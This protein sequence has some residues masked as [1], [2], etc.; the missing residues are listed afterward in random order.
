MNDSSSIKTNRT[1]DIAGGKTGEDWYN[2]RNAL[3]DPQT[4]LPKGDLAQWESVF[5]T[6]FE[7]RL[8]TRY[9]EPIR[10]I[11][12]MDLWHGEGFSIVAIQCSLIEFLQ[13][14]VEG[15]NYKYKNPQEPY[16]YNESRAMFKR[17]LTE[18]KPFASTFAEDDFADDF[19]TNVRCPVL[20]EARTTGGWRIHAGYSSDPL[21][22][23]DVTQKIVY[24]NNFQA[25]LEQFIAAYGER[26]QTDRDYQAAFIRKFDALAS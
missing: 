4:D 21:R 20:H 25:G 13:S 1:D 23:T 17:F 5:K 11:K 15:K 9:L 26:L 16:E 18:Q 7:T 8:R 2:D 19:Y 14:T 3:V 24:R 10:V 12:E 22:V 6:Y